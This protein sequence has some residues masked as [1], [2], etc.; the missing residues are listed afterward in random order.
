[1]QDTLEILR[2]EWIALDAGTQSAGHHF[3]SF[4]FSTIRNNTPELRTVI[5]RTVDENSSS[6]YFHTDLRSKKII[7]IEKLN[8]C[9]IDKQ[10]KEIKDNNAI[11]LSVMDPKCNQCVGGKTGKI[12]YTLMISI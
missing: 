6:L 12:C 2:E 9:I 7:D 4:I 11:S 10:Y 3:H 1:M 5:L 8:E